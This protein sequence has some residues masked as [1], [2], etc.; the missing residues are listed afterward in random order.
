MPVGYLWTVAVVSWGVACAL[1]RWRRLGFF[2][3]IPALVVSELP[4]LAGYLLVA[5]TVLAFADGDLGSPAGAA[6]AV[7]A[8]LALAGLVVIVRR[9]LRAH[10]AL[11]NAGQ[12]GRPWGRILRAP[13]FPGQ[14]DVVRVRGL[15]YGD[16]PDRTLDLYHRR[17]R[18]AG[19]PVLLHLHGGRFR[20]GSKSRE[21]RPLIRHL[22][23]RRGFVCVSADYR[24]QPD[25]TLAGQVA[26]VRD[27]IAWVRAHS[28]EFGAVPRGPLF[29]A[30]SSA[31]A[32]LAI[33]AVCDGETAIAGVIC[34]YGYYGGLAPTGDLP[35][36]LIVHGENDMWISA[37]EVRAFAD[38]LRAVSRRPVSYAEL[39]GAHHDFDLFESIRSAAVS[40]VVEQFAARVSASPDAHSQDR[41]PAQDS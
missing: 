31:G 4:F 16:G 13:F 18:P 40:T 27:A 5:S 28:A 21:A 32:N 33:R 36:V 15:A 14:L 1:T 39:P 2:A 6:G 11:G 20:S 19:A 34:R 35:P 29:L 9:A 41:Q 38:R 10:A 7:V 25:V 22:T 8:L 26:D 30:G 23:S 17:D 37:A 12:P 3:A 24:L